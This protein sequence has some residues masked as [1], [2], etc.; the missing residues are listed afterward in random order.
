MNY[1]SRILICVIILLQFVCPIFGQNV[2]IAVI[3]GVRYSEAFGSEGKYMPHMWN[4]LRPQGTIYTNF[5]NDGHTATIS[6]HVALMTGTRQKLINDGTQRSSHP[7][8]FEYFRKQKTLPEKSCYVVSGKTKLEALTYSTAAD[9]GS[10]YRASFSYGKKNDIE[11]WKELV[12]VMTKH[13]PPLVLVTF[14]ETDLN[15]HGDNWKGYLRTLQRADSLV[16][17]L[18]E[19]IQADSIYK[20]STTLFVTSDHGRH[21]DEHG[22]FQ[23]HGCSCEGCQHIMLLALGPKFKPNAVV[24][25]SSSQIDLTPTIA[26]I[27]GLTLP[28]LS[29]KS[30]INSKK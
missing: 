9:Y 12:D 20:N 13:H 17:L 1:I 18:W 21:D 10:K 29:G 11:T 30:L 6:G 24:S 23:D 14:V 2:F 16:N 8:L 7:T 3:D 26:Q 25:D 28:R 19:R 5:R 15:G 22:G 4:K 27:L